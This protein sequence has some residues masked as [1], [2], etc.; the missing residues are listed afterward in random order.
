MCFTFQTKEDRTYFLEIL[1][2]ARSLFDCAALILKPSLI[3]LH[4][5]WNGGSNGLGHVQSISILKQE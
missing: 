5:F 4:L 2:D 1:E 3:V